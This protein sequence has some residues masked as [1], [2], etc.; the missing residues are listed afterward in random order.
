MPPHPLAPPLL[1]VA[2]A[3][4]LVVA[5]GV[6]AQEETWRGEI[7]LTTTGTTSGGGP[8]ESWRTE[9]RWSDFRVVGGE[10]WADHVTFV[11]TWTVI[12]TRSSTSADCTSSGRAAGRGSYPWLRFEVDPF[13]DRGYLLAS[14]GYGGGPDVTGVMTV[15]CRLQAPY[16]VEYRVPASWLPAVPF[17]PPGGVLGTL[18]DDERASLP[19]ATLDMMRE[20]DAMLLEHDA[21]AGF[22]VRGRVSPDAPNVFE[23]TAT[24]EVEDGTMVLAWNLE[25]PVACHDDAFEERLRHEAAALRRLGPASSPAAWDVAHE[26]FSGSP[27]SA[28][29]AAAALRAAVGV[30]AVALQAPVGSGA[31]GIQSFGVRLSASGQVLPT[32]ETLR[33]QIETICVEEGSLEGARRLVVGSIQWDGNRYRVTVRSVDVET[34]VVI[35]AARVDGTGGAEALTAAVSRALSGLLLRS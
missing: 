3:L 12:E 23:G 9:E 14:G 31:A 2:I 17:A 21:D 33:Q 7:T 19:Q 30:D 16:D 34:G 26:A 28:A 25:R 4:L 29:D 11:A 32:V 27:L 15:R 5:T 20:I 1:T 13:D 8:V 18:T 22:G 35:G 24:R 6:R 10:P